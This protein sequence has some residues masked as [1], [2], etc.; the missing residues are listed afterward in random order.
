M[1]S[2]NPIGTFFAPEAVALVG[3]RSSPGFGYGIPLILKKRGWEERLFLV[4]PR[5]GVLHG[6]RVYKSVADCPAKV[7]LAVVIVP[8]PQVPQVLREIGEKGIRCV[9]IESAGFAETGEEGR[10][11]QE[12][13]KG[14]LKRYGIRALGPNCVGVVNTDNSFST[15][16]T[17]DEAMIPGN[18]A[19]I[20]Q[21]GVFG[22]ILLDKLPSEG[23]R[24]SKA[25]TLGNRIDVDETEIL[26]YLNGDPKTEVI[27][28]YLEGAADGRRLVETLKV[29]SRSKPV[30]V[31]KSGRTEQG[32]AATLSH[33]GSL[34]G[35]DA[36][37]DGA[38]AQ[39]GGI[40]ARTLAELIAFA[41]V[42][43]TQPLPS[44]P[45]L[46]IVTG[47]GSMGALATDAAVRAGLVIPPVSEATLREMRGYAPS[48]MNI[49]NPL[50]IG[51]SG[52]FEPALA[53]VARDPTI[54][55]ILA[56]FTIP[57]AV[58]LTLKGMGVEVRQ[59]LGELSALR[60][61]APD[62]PL[63]V[64]V[65]GHDEFVALV[66]AEAAGSNIPVLTSPEMA[67]EALAALW[68]YRRWRERAIGG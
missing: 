62:K 46:G 31:L 4:N 13:A 19:I 42:F 65:V 67:A 28:I 44:G 55:M 11:L 53:A 52:L 57:Y 26:T 45:R 50:D 23:I 5:V 12:E 1:P 64:C 20:A 34:A 29:V 14:I 18:T 38:F 21:S 58:L 22:N 37:Y 30:L 33:T 41:K 6:M 43:A 3:A 68:R 27:M 24:I 10:R 17:L 36:I 9:I 54:D 15:S 56:I 2:D 51:P 40:R 59:R 61:L 39:G 7:D 25:V 47:S 63:V 66:S 8:A 16:D 32:V 49:R 60:T 35:V 48:W